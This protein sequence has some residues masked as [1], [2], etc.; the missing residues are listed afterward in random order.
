MNFCSISDSTVTG[1]ANW[2]A[3]NASGALRSNNNIN[4]SNN[5]GW[6]YIPPGSTFGAF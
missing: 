6:D 3:F 4:A 2:N 1:G 5:S